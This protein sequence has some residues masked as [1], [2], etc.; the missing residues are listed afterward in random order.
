MNVHHTV[1]EL[2]RSLP[3]KA[4]IKMATLAWGVSHPAQTAVVEGTRTYNPE[5][6][7]GKTSAAPRWSRCSAAPGAR[8]WTRKAKRPKSR[9]SMS[10]RIRTIVDHMNAEVPLL[11]IASVSDA[12][13]ELR[14]TGLY[15]RMKKSSTQSS[16]EGLILARFECF[17]HS[18]ALELAERRRVV[19]KLA[20]PDGKLGI[21]D[22]G[23]INTNFQSPGRPRT[24]LRP[25][26]L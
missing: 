22:I 14:Y 25:I 11:S 9:S 19:C 10:F 24:C 8:S 3:I 20:S 6:A 26:F 16:A 12:V 7:N 13:S 15:A 18:G 17:A 1:E 23:L 5:I 21:T 2:F 4:L